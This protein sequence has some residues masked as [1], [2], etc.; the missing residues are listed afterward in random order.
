[1]AGWGDLVLFELEWE[2]IA[3]PRYRVSNPEI[4]RNN[5]AQYCHFDEGEIS[6]AR[7]TKIDAF[8]CGATCRDFS[9]VEMT[10]LRRVGML[11]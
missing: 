4:P 10:S 6:V 9:F 11:K 7:S 5:Y 1:M 8:D 2:Q 3:N